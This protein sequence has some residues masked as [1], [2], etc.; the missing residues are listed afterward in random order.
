MYNSLDRLYYHILESSR[1]PD[2]V[3]QVVGTIILLADPLSAGTLGQLLRLDVGGIRLALRRLQS[4]LVIPQDDDRPILVFH[5]S[6]HDFL[7]ARSR[8][9]HFY[10]DVST[11]HTNIARLCLKIITTAGCVRRQGTTTAEAGALTYAG[12]YWFEHIRLSNVSLPDLAPFATMSP[13]SLAHAAKIND[14]VSAR[15]FFDD[16][17]TVSKLRHLIFESG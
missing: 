12:Q 14:L 11:H 9:G 3:R 5:P 16:Y 15:N 17:I 10:V 1:H 6:F 7:T 4:V 8:A 13:P 2:R